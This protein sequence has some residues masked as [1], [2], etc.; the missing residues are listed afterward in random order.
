MN[1]LGLYKV[2]TA[3]YCKAPPLRA[4]RQMSK[5]YIPAIFQPTVRPSWAGILSY[6]SDEEKSKI[7]ESIIVYPKETDIKS[8]FWEETIKPDLDNQYQSFKDVCLARGRGAKSY[9]ESKGEDKLSSSLT[10]DIDK[11]NLLKDKDKDKDKNKNNNNINLNN[12]INIHYGE[13]K[14]V[15]LTQEQ[16][17]KLS[18]EHDNLD[19]AIEKLDTWLGTSGRKNKNRNH[20]AYF[21]SNSWVWEG[22]KNTDS[23]NRE[24]KETENKLLN[25]T[26]DEDLKF[27]ETL[28]EFSD[29]TFDECTRAYEWLQRNM[30]MKTIPK[31]KFVEIVHKFKN[32]SQK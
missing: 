6:I 9:W 10:K 7:L 3:K 31:T 19:L 24:K 30:Y 12:N 27:D 16:F 2:L 5:K 23:L 28:P 25:I 32:Y 29:M 11:D 20:Y 15:M 13:L 18:A 1:Y 14:N 26:I 4:V 21:K 17:D 22:L 8:K